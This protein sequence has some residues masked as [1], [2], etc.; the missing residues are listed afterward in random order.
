MKKGLQGSMEDAPLTPTPYSGGNNP[1][2]P[3]TT[4]QDLGTQDDTLQLY[5]QEM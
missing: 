1:T 5:S 4:T 2:R 3:E